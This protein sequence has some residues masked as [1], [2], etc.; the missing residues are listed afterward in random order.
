MPNP[1]PTSVPVVIGE[2]NDIVN[3]Q[4]RETKRRKG[5]GKKK[6]SAGRKRQQIKFPLDYQDSIPQIST[7]QDYHI[8]FAN[9]AAAEDVDGISLLGD[10]FNLPR[11]EVINTYLNSYFTRYHPHLPFLH[12]PTFISTLPTTPPPL[13]LSVLS[14]GALLSHARDEAVVLHIASKVL[15]SHFLSRRGDFDS[16]QCPLW[17]MQTT[18]LNMIF[19]SWSGDAKALEWTCSIKSLLGNLV[20][21]SRY[22]L[23]LRTEKW[24]RERLDESDGM[25]AEGG[26][27]RRVPSWDEWIDEEG[28]RRTYFAVYVFFGLLTLVFNHPNSMS[29]DEL[30]E[31]ELPCEEEIWAAPRD[32][33]EKFWADSAASGETQAQTST[34]TSTLPGDSNAS[35]DAD[36]NDNGE[37]DDEND[38]DEVEEDLLHPPT[39]QAAHDAFFRGE[40]LRYSPFATRIMINV[41]FYEVWNHK[42]TIVSLQD[43]VTE[44]KLRLA[45]DGW[46]SS[47]RAKIIEEDKKSRERALLLGNAVPDDGA[48]PPHPLLANSLAVYR[49]AR[50]RLVVDLKPLQEALRYHSPYEIAASMT[51]ARDLVKRD[52]VSI[53]EGVVRE[54]CEGMEEVVQMFGRASTPPPS[55]RNLMTGAQ[56]RRTSASSSPSPSSSS[57]GSTTPA[58]PTTNPPQ[59]STTT[60]TT[61][62]CGL[63]P[64]CATPRPRLT[65]SPAIKSIWGVEHPLCI[66]DM[67]VILTLWLYRLENAGQ[68]VFLS[69]STGPDVEPE[70]DASEFEIA[71]YQRVR[72]LFGGIDEEA[73]RARSPAELSAAVARIWGEV[74]DPEDLDSLSV[75]AGDD[76]DVDGESAANA[77]IWGIEKIIGESFKLHSQALIGYLDDMSYVSATAGVGGE[78]PPLEQQEQ[79]RLGG[80]EGGATPTQ[81]NTQMVCTEPECRDSTPL[82]SSAVPPATS[83]VSFGPQLPT[84]G[85]ATTTTTSSTAAAT[86]TSANTSGG[87]QSIE[88]LRGARGLPSVGTAY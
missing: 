26:S 22:A 35:G 19:G 56:S 36:K 17:A 58:A 84:S 79:H 80:S 43:V 57:S 30:D 86:A 61:F 64:V 21:G 24:E 3:G 23:R 54:C 6:D 13:L 82:A 25:G 68:T 83:G 74:L 37:D 55:S 31:F 9:I 66:I 33:V 60:N 71:L 34:S 27:R 10:T 76:V 45:L 32:V 18:L 44:F 88:H 81:T 16:R 12:I 72:N 15:V 69:N 50:I 78:V 59:T 40:K 65:L 7:E 1:G 29:G 75:E 47:L 28:C 73:G 39:V 4:L 8:L 53:M 67:L 2:G 41:L 51:V 52:T 87:R 42:R 5:I 20:S 63:T 14:L 48:R 85:D 49:T 77:T 46:E 11:R 62:S 70:P 38:D